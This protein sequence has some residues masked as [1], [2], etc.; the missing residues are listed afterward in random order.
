MLA[1]RS[2]QPLACLAFSQWLEGPVIYTS[3]THSML[4]NQ[5]IFMAMCAKFCPTALPFG[6][7]VL[8]LCTFQLYEATNRCLLL[9]NELRWLCSY[10]KS[11]ASM[12]A[13]TTNQ[14][15]MFLKKNKN[16]QN[17][18]KFL[19]LCI[20]AFTCQGRKFRVRVVI[21]YLISVTAFFRLLNY[22]L[23]HWEL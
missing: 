16:E 18:W 20:L 12:S 9:C 4:R 21:S 17:N 22:V 1:V 3:C 5:E 23:T 11:A 2:H 14:F 15:A 7:D 6:I 19:I 8:Y 10:R 13:L